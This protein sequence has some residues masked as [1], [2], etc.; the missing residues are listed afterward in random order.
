[1][2]LQIRRR[3]LPPEWATVPFSRWIMCHRDGTDVWNRAD[4]AAS[5]QNLIL[6]NAVAALADMDNGDG[7]HI[8]RVR[9]SELQCPVTLILG[10]RS[11]T[12]FHRIAATLH[13]DCTHGGA[14]TRGGVVAP[15][16]LG[17]LSS[18]TARRHAVG[19]VART[20]HA[21]AD[22]PR[23]RPRPSRCW[24][25]RSGRSIRRLR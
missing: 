19:T 20:G 21:R 25:G 2:G 12:W 18:T 7:S 10:E 14:A 9:L 24:S 11:Q 13:P 22:Q 23:S 3:L 15:A 17:R 1:V 16:W 4:Y 6:P 8:D 5:R